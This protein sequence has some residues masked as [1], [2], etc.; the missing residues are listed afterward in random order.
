MAIDLLSLQPHKVSRDLSGYITYIYG[1]PKIGKTSLAVSFPNPLLLAFER[2]Y[3]TLDGIMVQDITTWSEMR[4]VFRELKKP[5]VK[6]VFK[7]VIVDTVDLASDMCQK[8][9]CN[10]KGIDAL[11]DLGYGERLCRSKIAVKNW[12]LV[13][14][15][16][17]E[18]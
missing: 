11:G 6:N 9:I 15:I 3:N 18:V 14:G 8:Y 4:Q 2:G 13:T 12:N 7:T 10:Q 17:A 16:R 1:P 5:E